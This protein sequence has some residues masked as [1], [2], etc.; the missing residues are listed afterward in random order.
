MGKQPT[1]VSKIPEG[2]VFSH[3]DEATGRDIYKT[4]SSTPKTNTPVTP[5]KQKTTPSVSTGK[6]RV[7]RPPL[8]RKTPA[9][10]TEDYVYMENQVPDSAETKIPLYEDLRIDRKLQAPI[11]P[12]IDYFKYPDPNAGYSKST[13]KY[14]DKTTGKEI[15]INKSLPE[16]NYLPTYLD[17]VLKVNEGANLG[18][19]KQ[20]NPRVTSTPEVTDVMQGVGKERSGTKGTST[21]GTVG[22]EK[23]GRVKAPK[24]KGYYNGTTRDGVQSDRAGSDN[25]KRTSNEPVYGASSGVVG[26][27]DQYAATKAKEDDKAKKESNAKLATA[28]GGAAYNVGN[29]LYKKPVDIYADPNQQATEESLNATVDATAN[30]IPV[31]GTWYGAAMGANKTGRSMLEKDKYGDVKGGANQAADEMM[32]SSHEHAIEAAS[33]GDA[34]GTV[35]EITGVG[36]VG[37]TITNLLGKQNETTGTWGDINKAFGTTEKNETRNKPFTQQLAE[38]KAANEKDKIAQAIAARNAGNFNPKT[39]LKYNVGSDPSY[40]ENKR[41]LYG[42]GQTYMGEESL[43]KGGPVHNM[44]MKMMHGKKHEQDCADGGE[45]KGKGTGTSDEIEAEVKE[46]SF[47][48]PAKNADLAKGIRKLYLKAPVKN[49]NLKQDG[50]ESV[51]LSNGEVMFTPQENEYLESIGVDLEALAP[52]AEHGE[53]EMAKGGPVKG[54]KINGVTYDGKNWI[55]ASGNKY[56]EEAG[57][58]FDKAYT[59]SIEKAKSNETSRLGSEINVY[60]RKLNEANASG[61]TA[62][63]DRLQSKINQLTGT[64]KEVEKTPISEIKKPSFKAPLVKK[65]TSKSTAPQNVT[66]DMGED[67]VVPGGALSP[68]EIEL[69]KKTDATSAYNAKA[70]SDSASATGITPDSMSEYGKQQPK[71]R[72]LLDRIGNIDPTSLVGV[73]QMVAGKNMLSGEVRPEDKAILDATY[74]ANVNRAMQD[75]Q[76]GLTPEQK[77]QAEQD[78]ANAQRDAMAQGVSYA[79]G[80][81]TKAFNLN[82]AA[83]NDAWK[84]KLGLKTADTELRMQ[85]QQYADQQAAQRASILAANR[86]QAFNDAMGTFQQKQEAGSE[87][88]GA[89]LQNTIGAYRF[90]KDQQAR[91]EAN[92]ASNAW[93]SQI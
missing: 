19:E 59:Q 73:G 23:G 89:G 90:K 12:N 60:K 83:I 64:K 33:K 78:I 66:Q 6:P 57:K 5:P 58:R 41:L 88:I 10:S 53:D 40:D 24:V 48:V 43:A 82:R 70:L 39:T 47:I 74:N 81:G 34:A 69:A 35:R 49:A 16:G 31:V 14:F 1:K 84:N 68:N 8:P 25:T 76:F 86:R 62:E 42:D 7:L 72:S 22:F 37:R 28:L 85:K 18:T 91:D 15:D 13:S 52:D 45:I 32:Q 17:N 75:A 27:Q 61:N 67:V 63:A 54:T 26:Q 2:Y 21:M 50:G 46:G 36:K 87:L 3:K 51:K 79:G 80:S 93:T 55:D 29:A 77:F 20:G 30:A 56:S 65:E 71:G 4:E 38:V 9:T 11:N 44:K 92:K